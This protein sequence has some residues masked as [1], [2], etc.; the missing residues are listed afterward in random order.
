M[1]AINKITNQYEYPSIAVKTNSYICPDCNKDVI[2]RKGTIRIHHF[3]HHKSENPCQYY[4]NPGESQI[5]KDAKMALKLLLE[6]PRNINIIRRCKT[7]DIADTII[8]NKNIISCHTEIEY[9][10]KYND[11]IKIAD[12]AYLEGT[13][14]K[15][16]F[17]ICYKHKTNTNDRPEPWFEIDAEHLLN[18]INIF[19]DMTSKID[20]FCIRSENCIK[21]IYDKQKR[22]DFYSILIEEREKRLVLEKQE[23]EKKLLNELEAA[24]K[25]RLEELEKTR[26]KEIEDKK[27]NEIH[28]MK[29]RRRNEIIEKLRSEH[30]KC[31]KCKSYDRCKNCVNKLWKKCYEI[32]KT[33]PEPGTETFPNPSPPHTPQ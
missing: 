30:K 11:M 12:L 19:N 2:L 15:Y 17:E 22:Q 21:C 9:R 27:R 3:A 1:G 20:I 23:Y 26:L 4:T 14:I 13:D 24:E 18:T 7:C 5:H 10:F 33:I 25:R 28:E 31:S 8:I 32:L 16:I 6:Q 29:I